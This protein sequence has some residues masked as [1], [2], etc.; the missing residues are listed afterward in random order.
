MLRKMQYPSAAG[1]ELLSE[2]MA[3]DFVLFVSC[4]CTTRVSTKNYTRSWHV[5]KKKL[6]LLFLE[7]LLLALRTTTYATMR[8][9]MIPNLMWLLTHL[10]QQISLSSVK[11]VMRV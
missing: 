4:C 7:E 3:R 9:A 10:L 5:R 11:V 2:V 6:F 8:I 1:K